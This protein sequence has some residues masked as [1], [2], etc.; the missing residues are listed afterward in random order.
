MFTRIRYLLAA[1][2]RLEFCEAGL[3]ARLDQFNE[4]N[5]RTLRPSRHQTVA[6]MALGWC[7]P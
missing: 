6:G 2:D 1:F 5:E 7:E 4:R 3:V